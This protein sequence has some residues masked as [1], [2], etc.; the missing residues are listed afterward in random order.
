MDIIVNG[1]FDLSKDKTYV[2]LTAEK[3]EKGTLSV[4]KGVTVAKIKGLPDHEF[5]DDNELKE[6]IEEN[7]YVLALETPRWL[8]YN[9]NPQLN[10]TT[11]CTI[12]AY[13]AAEGIDWEIAYGIACDKGKELALM[14]NDDKTVHEIL[15]NYFGYEYVKL[16]KDEKCT[17]KEFA[18]DHTKGRFILNCTHHLVTVV[19]GEYWDSWDSGEKKVKGYYIKTITKGV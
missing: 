13:C 14:P 2:V 10:K 18:I 17:V 8:A 5:A 4:K 11:D 6:W 19:D 16:T 7:N 12:R 3:D 1:L 9:P 15:E